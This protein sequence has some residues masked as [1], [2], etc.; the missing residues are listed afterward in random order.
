MTLQ[1]EAKHDLKERKKRE[2][3]PLL[4]SFIAF[5]A[6]GGLERLQTAKA[7]RADVSLL[8]FHC[9]DTASC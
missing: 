3:N 1:R 5:S 4:L 2:W 8:I 9:A 7:R 6:S